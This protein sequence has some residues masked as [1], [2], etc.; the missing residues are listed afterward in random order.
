MQRP[1]AAAG[2]GEL[3][4]DNGKTYYMGVAIHDAGAKGRKHLVSLE[5][6]IAIGSGTAD[7]VAQGK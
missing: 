5:R 6:S 1:L 7:I 4:L 3:A 2:K